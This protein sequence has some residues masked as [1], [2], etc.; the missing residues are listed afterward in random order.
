M[1]TGKMDGKKHPLHPP[2]HGACD[3]PVHQRVTCAACHST[4]VPQC[5]GCHA[6]QDKRETHLDKLTLKE[7]PGWWEEGRSYIRYEKPMLAVWPDEGGDRD[8]RLPGHRDPDRR[9]GKPGGSST[10]SP[11]PP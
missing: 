4:W 9:K 11:W 7:T 2:K 10:A 6:K 3:A 5:Y 1:L 8:P